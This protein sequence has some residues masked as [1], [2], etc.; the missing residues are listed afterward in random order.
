MM[1]CLSPSLS[2]CRSHTNC[3]AVWLKCSMLEMQYDWNAVWLH[4]GVVEMQY[5][6]IVVWLKCSMVALR[7]GIHV[8]WKWI[9]AFSVY[10]EITTIYLS[11][12]LSIVQKHYYML[13]G[14]CGIFSDLMGADRFTATVNMDN[15]PVICILKTRIIQFKKSTEVLTTQQTSL[16]P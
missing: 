13:M 6:C 4:C 10:S 11:P 9:H 12:I 16:V 2:L 7:Y 14:T 3:I 1:T 5:G 8:D 15:E